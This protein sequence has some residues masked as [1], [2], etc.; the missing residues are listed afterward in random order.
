[1]KTLVGFFV[2]PLYQEEPEKVILVFSLSQSQAEQNQKINF[3]LSV[4]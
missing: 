4:T 2:R 3:E 1:M